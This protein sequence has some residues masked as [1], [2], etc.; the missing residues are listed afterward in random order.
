MAGASSGSAWPPDSILPEVQFVLDWNPL[1]ML[2]GESGDVDMATQGPPGTAPKAKKNTTIGSSRKATFYDRH[3]A[4]H[5]IL[6]R[7]VYLDE[8][9]SII[10][11]TVDQAIHDAVANHPL[12]QHSG[13]LLPAEIIKCQVMRTD[14]TKYH[15]QGIAEAYRVHTAMYCIPIASTIAIHPSSGEWDQLLVWTVDGKDGRWAIAD[16]V[17]RMSHDICKD[18]D[19][20]QDLLKKEDDGKIALLKELDRCSTTLAVWEMKSLTVGT[21]KVMTEIFEMGLTHAKFRWVK[22]TARVCV[23]ERLEYMAECRETYDEGVDPRS[24]PWTLPDNPS[25]PTGYSRP[26]S[27]REGLR[28]ASATG[29]ARGATA[30]ISYKE[31]SLSSLEDGEGV[32]GKRRHNVTDGSDYDQPPAKK[33]KSVSMDERDKD[34]QPSPGDRQEVTAQSFLQQVTT[35]VFSQH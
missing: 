27:R 31:S 5:L 4:S 13:L 3:L 11:S 8:L 15:E 16:A 9:V 35:M 33:S 6:E 14:W 2:V 34:Y 21:E 32:G 29:A 23:H 10:A 18:D 1:R 28:N 26:T 7:V 30:R 17:L 20:V 25:T 24:P 22:C 12:P 19:S